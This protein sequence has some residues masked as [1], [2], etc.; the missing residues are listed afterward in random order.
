MNTTNKTSRQRIEALEEQ[1]KHLLHSKADKVGTGI[2]V[3]KE[4][5]ALEGMVN[6][7]EG[8]L[9]STNSSLDKV[10]MRIDAQAHRLNTLTVEQ[11]SIQSASE[12]AQ[13]DATENR[14]RLGDLEDTLVNLSIGVTGAAQQA[15][16]FEAKVKEAFEKTSDNFD[17]AASVVRIN[18]QTLQVLDQKVDTLATNEAAALKELHD[19]VATNKTDSMTRDVELSDDIEILD[20][21][22]NTAMNLL[23]KSGDRITKAIN[24][25]ALQS[26]TVKEDIAEL[27]ERVDLSLQGHELVDLE[28]ELRE[29]IADC[30][31]RID[32]CLT[33]SQFADLKDELLERLNACDSEIADLS[34]R[35]DLTTLEEG[36]IETFRSLVSDWQ[37]VVDQSSIIKELKT[38]LTSYALK[39]SERIFDLEE[40]VSA[41]DTKIKAVDRNWDASHSR[42]NY[43]YKTNQERD[44]NINS[45]RDDLNDL[46]TEALSAT[47]RI[48]AI[49][50]SVRQ[51]SSR[52]AVTSEVQ[53]DID[54]LNKE[55]IDFSLR[56]ETHE[57]IAKTQVD[58]INKQGNLLND[59]KTEMTFEKARF[60][61]VAED[62]LL[63]QARNVDDIRE[64]QATLESMNTDKS[65]KTDAEDLL[66]SI[67]DSRTC[68]DNEV[69]QRFEVVDK[70]LE[71]FGNHL[72]ET[73]T[74]FD[75]RFEKL[76][77]KNVDDDAAL[78]R[79]YEALDKDVATLSSD[80]ALL[81]SHS[82]KQDVAIATVAKTAS[83]TNTKADNLALSLKVTNE[84]IANA[85]DRV[86]FLS[87]KVSDNKDQVDTQLSLLEGKVDSAD[88]NTDSRIVEV[89]SLLSGL[90]ANQRELE[91]Q[92]EALTDANEINIKTKKLNLE[93]EDV[94]FIDP[95]TG[96]EANLG[97]LVEDIT[98]SFQVLA[99]AKKPKSLTLVDRKGRTYSFLDEE[100]KS[101]EIKTKV[102]KRRM[103][104]KE[105][106]KSFI[107]L[108]A[109]L[110]ILSA[111]VFYSLFFL[112]VDF[113]AAAV[114]SVI[115]TFFCIESF[116]WDNQTVIKKQHDVYKI[117]L[118]DGR[119]AKVKAVRTIS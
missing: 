97:D 63:G 13:G 59:L 113:A 55:S 116:P 65:A 19:E 105:S 66:Q 52:Q 86:G 93:V 18:R 16:N 15:V 81:D 10:D 48:D 35:L 56:M 114:V 47:D 79:S 50:N 77:Q 108:S 110:T 101:L 11:A 104:G 80:I 32:E 84:D 103:I 70:S 28:G 76:E 94:T 119:K 117:K 72:A 85:E 64:I 98:E 9:V 12:N 88:K 38:S 106:K 41:L 21:R 60:T 23:R 17:S 6:D 29:N 67:E 22:V 46:K 53:S 43:I 75:Q 69:E 1:T 87:Q 24:A 44:G 54:T 83:K 34:K 107:S 30:D 8:D 68:L 78:E 51:I 115:G 33:D 7:F 73:S 58:K 89:V 90:K 3:A 20:A 5:S 25:N 36:E 118:T 112:G 14:K 39:S 31:Q 57:L 61:A 71:N 96:L 49:D 40:S 95:A 109:A 42:L 111:V 100:I 99:E 102:K 82:D 91:A 4:I 26:A 2:N 92:V 27:S 45:N 37:K 62:T 74:D